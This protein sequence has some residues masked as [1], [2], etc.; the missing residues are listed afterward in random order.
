[1][2]QILFVLILNI[3]IA[4]SI[5]S[6]NTPIFK[7]I[8]KICASQIKR[9]T[10]TKKTPYNIT[11]Y[12]V[13]LTDLVLFVS[14][15]AQQL[16]SQSNRKNHNYSDLMTFSRNRKYL[17]NNNKFNIQNSLYYF[18]SDYVFH[19]PFWATLAHL[20]LFHIF[21]HPLDLIFCLVTWSS[22]L[23]HLSSSYKSSN[24]KFIMYFWFYQD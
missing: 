8:I 22:S 5:I 17:T 6:L 2:L 14:F 4:G 18:F 19:F 11:K 20:L 13:S 16:N 3:K 23:Q 15:V 1:M 10:K 21:I 9:K 7:E 24:C 12:F